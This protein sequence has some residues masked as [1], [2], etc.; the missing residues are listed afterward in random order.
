MNPTHSFFWFIRQVKPNLLPGNGRIPQTKSSAIPALSLFTRTRLL[1][2]PKALN[3]NQSWSCP[4]PSPN[5][6]PSISNP[7]LT[8]T[9][10][11]LTLTPLSLTLTLLSLTLT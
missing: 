7:H 6:Q 2:H 8:L 9:P 1:T 11:S 5:P 10:L 3:P 4:S